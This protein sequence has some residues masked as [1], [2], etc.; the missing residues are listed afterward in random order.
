MINFNITYQK[1]KELFLLD[2]QLHNYLRAFNIYTT[3]T[4]SFI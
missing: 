4:T 2:N 1:C 3:E